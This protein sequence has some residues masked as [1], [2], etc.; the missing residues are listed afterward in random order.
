M[1]AALAYR[2]RA[3]AAH[4]GAGVREQAE[5]AI[6]LTNL[7]A[8]WSELGQ[9][10][11]ARDLYERAL[12][13]DEREFGPDHPQVAVA[14]STTWGP[15]GA[16]WGSRPR[17]ATCMSGRHFKGQTGAVLH[18]AVALPRV[19]VETVEAESTKPRRQVRVGRCDRPPSAELRFL[20]G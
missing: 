17:P 8:A 11:K 20:F 7:G 12:R 15:R 16:I 3:G 18:D 14:S 5:V 13:I 2:G 10:A 4:Q 6:T 1:L 9:P 19:H